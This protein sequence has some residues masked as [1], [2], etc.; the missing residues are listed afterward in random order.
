[1]ATQILAATRVTIVRRLFLIAALLIATAASAQHQAAATT[2][3]PFIGNSYTYYNEMPWLFEQIAKSRGMELRTNMSIEGG[4][5]LKRLW[6]EG[7]APEAIRQARFDYVVIQPQSSEIVRMPDETRT[8]ARMFIKSIRETGAQPIFF[9]PWPPAQF[10]S[11]Q[12]QFRTAYR[13]LASA[14]HVRLAPV[15]ASWQAVKW[16]GA[17]LYS[18][19]GSHPNLNGSYLAACVFFAMIFDQDP[20]GATHTFAGP[21]D[22]SEEHH[23]ALARERISDTTALA[24]QR[25]AW[26]AVRK[27][28]LAKR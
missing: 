7:R 6:D 17:E 5:T 24:L 12:V 26:D 19:D 9:A 16:G 25:A 18:A 27:E 13:T 10:A 20:T 4:A 21:F 23:A 1:V 22:T 15:D 11:S 28:P 3:V 2:R 8:Y 14:L